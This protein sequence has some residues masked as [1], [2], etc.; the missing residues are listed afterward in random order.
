MSAACR[1]PENF[2]VDYA[3][4][5]EMQTA[6]GSKMYIQNKMEEYGEQIFSLLDN[7]AHIYFCGLKGAPP[8]HMHAPPHPPPPP[9]LVAGAAAVETSLRS[10]KPQ[11]GRLAVGAAV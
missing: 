11:R 1:Y 2:R 7:G 5:R 10:W 3:L 8:H 4:S 9:L 6:D